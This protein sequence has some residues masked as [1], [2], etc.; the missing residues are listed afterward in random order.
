L[1]FVDVPERAYIAGNLGVY[2]M[3]RVELLRDVFVWA[4]ERCCQRYVIVRDSIAEPDRF[5]MR[6]RQA[7]T[8]V[9]GQVIREK[10]LPTADEIRRRAEQVV[11]ARD[12]PRFVGLAT[13]EFRRLS[14]HNIGRYR[15]RLSEYRAWHRAL[16]RAKATQ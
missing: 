8:D 6:Y 10:R 13:A 5:R 14:E 9:I 15:L 16:L 3:T 1:S 12:V 11:A 7:L 2:E 4:Y